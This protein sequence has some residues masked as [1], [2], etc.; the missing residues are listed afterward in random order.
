[1][2]E[3]FWEN[4]VV[5]IGSR[6][7]TEKYIFAIIK[8]MNPSVYDKKE[9]GCIVIQIRE[10]LIDYFEFIKRL[11]K[12]I[13]LK[14]VSRVKKPMDIGAY[15]LQEAYEIKLEKIPVLQMMRADDEDG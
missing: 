9:H 7:K 11:V 10:S 12:W 15:T 14:E 1:M 8:K 3:K 4:N 2:T 6:D 13:G 5:I